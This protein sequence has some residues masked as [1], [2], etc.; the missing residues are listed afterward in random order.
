MNNKL[1][2]IKS[3]KKILI[4][5]TTLVLLSVSFLTCKPLKQSFANNSFIKQIN[6]SIAKNSKVVLFAMMGNDEKYGY[7]DKTGK[8][9]I[10]PQFD[11]VENFSEGL[12]A[13]V[14]GGKRGYIDK[15]G[16]F[17]DGFLYEW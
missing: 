8:I 15:T 10:E 3:W 11:I 12:A 14:I 9:V 16:V 17:I 1:K 4:G 2:N 7:I 5:S 6:T 13:V